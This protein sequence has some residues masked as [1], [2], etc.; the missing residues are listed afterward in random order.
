MRTATPLLALAT[1]ALVGCGPQGGP[2]AGPA[3]RFLVSD[4]AGGTQAVST[5]DVDFGP[6]ERGGTATLPVVV[7]NAGTGD[8]ALSGFDFLAGDDAVAW[9]GVDA[10]APVFRL[11]L[12]GDDTLA[13]GQTKALSATF[14]PPRDAPKGRTYETQL[15]LSHAGE[16]GS[17]DTGRFTLRGQ[18]TPLDCAVP[19]RLDFGAVTRGER[20]RLVLTLHNPSPTV[21]RTVRVGAPTSPQGPGT[22]TLTPESP[23]GVFTLVPGEAREVRVDFAPALLASYQGALAVQVHEACPEVSVAL[24]GEGVEQTLTWTPAVVDFEYVTPG[25]FLERAVTFS[26]VAL[27]PVTVADL[28]CFEGATPSARFSVAAGATTLTVPSATRDEADALVPGT[29]T[30]TLRFAPTETGVKAGVLRGDVDGR[31]PASLAVAL[32]GVGGGP[33]LS[34]SPRDVAVGRVPY[35]AGAS[36]PSYATREVLVE[37]VGPPLVIPDARWN[38]K[39]GRPDTTGVPQRPYWEVTGLTPARRRAPTSTASPCRS[40]PTCC[41]S[42]TTAARCPTSRWS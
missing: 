8:L 34:V 36:P 16:P 30:L 29:A 9:P 19:A 32:R 27:R 33:D 18:L 23:L 39:L 6:V 7:L 12:E 11:A 37:N 42:S 41:S 15:R 4:G 2:P 35:F 26:N 38:L 3:L 13:P 21:S 10:S 17:R 31:G 40:G 1:L 22:F 20:E 14:E 24:R 25:G 28:R 5:A